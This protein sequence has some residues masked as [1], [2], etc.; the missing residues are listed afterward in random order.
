MITQ[1]TCSG[2]ASKAAAIAGKAMLTIES[3][4]TTN[5]PAAAIS[6]PISPLGSAGDRPHLARPRPI[7]P[8]GSAGDRPHLA[9]P[10][11]ISPL[12]SA[13]DRPHLARPRPISPLGS[14]GGRPHLARPRPISPLGSAGGRPHLA[15]PSHAAY[16]DMGLLSA[17]H[18][19]Y[20][21]PMEIE[22]RATAELG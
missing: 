15:R 13:G 7:S 17:R 19:R 1:R 4:D 8:L 10:R 16:D 20:K 22:A 6:R 5:A 14:A 11:P 21:L 2:G 12:G 18:P 3:S 9:R